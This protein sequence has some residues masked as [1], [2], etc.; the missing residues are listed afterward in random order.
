RPVRGDIVLIPSTGAYNPTFLASN[1]NSFP[2]PARILLDETG[3]WSYLKQAD[4]YEEMFA[5]DAG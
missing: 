4:T 3:A 2:R 5:A 1:A